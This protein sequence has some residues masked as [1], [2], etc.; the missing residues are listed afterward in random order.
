MG[1]FDTGLKKEKKKSLFL[2]TEQGRL[3]KDKTD[4]WHLQSWVTLFPVL[5]LTLPSHPISSSWLQEIKESVPRTQAC[6]TQKQSM[7]QKAHS[8]G[9]RC[10]ITPLQLLSLGYHNRLKY[11]LYECSLLD[12]GNKA[13]LSL[14]HTVA[15]TRHFNQQIRSIFATNERTLEVT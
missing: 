10:V 6:L 14:S 1:P 4:G 9:P 7:H 8:V 5:L 2:G 3:L 13:Q 11:H 15:P 12:S